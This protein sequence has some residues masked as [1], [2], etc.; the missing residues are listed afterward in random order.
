MAPGVGKV[1]KP[2]GFKVVRANP[3]TGVIHDF[4]V[5]RDAYGPAS[6]LKTGGIERP[7]AVRFSP[8]GS[9]LYIVDFGVMLTTDKGPVP[10][11]KTGVVWK[12]IKTGKQ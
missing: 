8:D 2:V 7:V 4:V 1:Y 12:V 5:N 9:T 10:M 11:E 3:E 6:K